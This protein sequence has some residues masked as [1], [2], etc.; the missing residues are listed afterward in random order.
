MFELDYG[1]Q[2]RFKKLFESQSVKIQGDSVNFVALAKD[3]YLAEE[4]LI[5]TP[6]MTT[7]QGSDSLSA[8]H[9]TLFDGKVMLPAIVWYLFL[10][11]LLFLLF[12][13]FSSF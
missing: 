11:F 1:F 7:S 4:Y 13:S 12:F 5:V 2:I 10:F 9:T 8:S 6:F 3:P